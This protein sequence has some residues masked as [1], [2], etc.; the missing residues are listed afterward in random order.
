MGAGTERGSL[1]E[2]FEFSSKCDGNSL[3]IFFILFYFFKFIY[4]ETE[5]V[6]VCV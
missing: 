5:R 2:E 4:F 3:E 1:Q 6:C